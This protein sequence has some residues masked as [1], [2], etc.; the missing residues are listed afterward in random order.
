M[1]AMGATDASAQGW[2][3]HGGHVY[4]G[5][6]SLTHHF[7]PPA[8]H[9]CGVN[10]FGHQVPCPQGPPWVGVPYHHGGGVG[11][12]V[13][14]HPHGGVGVGVHIPGTTIFLGR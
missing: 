2:Q 7:R 12:G 10:H 1:L 8:I 9:S 6:P 13:Q 11:V 3:K 14:V 4:Q 5:P